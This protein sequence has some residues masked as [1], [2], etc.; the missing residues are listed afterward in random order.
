M[1]STLGYIALRCGLCLPGFH[2]ITKYSCYYPIV[3][4]WTPLT[5]YKPNRINIV[6]KI[7]KP[8]KRKVIKKFKVHMLRSDVSSYE[9][10]LLFLVSAGFSYEPKHQLRTAVSLGH[11]SF[12]EVLI[13]KRLW[14]HLCNMDPG[15][16][17]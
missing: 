14:V 7:I 10:F 1:Y 9:L 12:V 4:M 2:Y 15:K 17:F 16:I 13:L 8:V 11:P 6:I 5:V 3:F